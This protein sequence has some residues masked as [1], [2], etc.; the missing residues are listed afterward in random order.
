MAKETPELQHSYTF[1]GDMEP[2]TMKIHFADYDTGSMTATISGKPC[3][4]ASFSRESAP[5][6]ASTIYMRATTIFNTETLILR[7]D[8]RS[9]NRLYGTFT[10][11]DPAISKP[12]ELK[13]W[14]LS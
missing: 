14:T 11:L 3:Q 4:S 9:Y 12:V 6:T 2:R 13:K 10:S 5:S 7:A 1:Q 8:D